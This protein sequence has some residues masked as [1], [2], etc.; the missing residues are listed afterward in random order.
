MLNDKELTKKLS[1]GTVATIKPLDECCFK[2]EIMKGKKVVDSGVW[3]PVSQVLAWDGNV[4]GFYETKEDLLKA[5]K[6]RKM[7]RTRY[8]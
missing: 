7:S 6:P 8:F 3:C 5:I 4:V 2:I 1:N